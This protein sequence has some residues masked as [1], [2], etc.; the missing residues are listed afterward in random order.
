MWSSPKKFE[1]PWSI[2]IGQTVT[3]AST[4]VSLLGTAG[5][6]VCFLRTNWYCMCGSSQQG[7]QH[8]FDLFSAACEQAGTKISTKSIEVLCLSK[9][10]RQ[11]ILQVSGNTL[12]QLET[13]KY[14]GVVFTS[15]RSRNKGIDTWIDKTNAVLRDL[16]CSVVTKRELS[17]TAKHSV[18]KPIFVPILTCGHESYSRW[19]LREY[20]QKN[21]RQRWDICEEFL[22]W[23]FATKSTGLKSLKTGMSRHF[24]EL[25]DPSYVSSA[26]YPECS[27]KEWRTN[28]FALQSTP[29]RKRPKFCP[30]RASPARDSPHRK[31][32]HENEWMN[33]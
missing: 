3:G 8:A 27:R 13:F 11:C 24:S 33:M 16:H 20:Y 25:R 19:R 26:M 31:S 7:L 1:E 22:V 5:L 30:A 21:K 17:K 6:T 4:R 12:Q 9:H 23:H 29:T 32:W 15:D 28:S 18:F 10:P 14:L 2:W